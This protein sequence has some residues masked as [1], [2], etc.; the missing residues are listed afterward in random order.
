V[1]VSDLETVVGCRRLLKREAI[2]AGGSSGAVL[3]ALDQMQDT[4]EDGTTCV[5]LLAYRGLDTIYSDDWVHAHFGDIS[6][7]WIE[8]Q[9]E[10][11]RS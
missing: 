1:H 2:L 9:R 10:P 6:H 4:I 5:V 11:V 7:Y 3:A 8:P